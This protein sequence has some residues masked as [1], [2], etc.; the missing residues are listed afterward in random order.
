MNDATREV[1]VPTEDSQ[2][3]HYH[4]PGGCG[5]HLVEKVEATAEDLVGREL[6]PCSAAGCESADIP[7]YERC[8]GCGKPVFD[9][10]D[11][12][13]SDSA[14]VDYCAGCVLH[15]QENPNDA[16]HDQ[17]SLRPPTMLVC[18]SCMATFEDTA[19]GRAGMEDHDCLPPAEPPQEDR[20]RDCRAD[21]CTEVARPLSSYCSGEC[22]PDVD[23]TPDGDSDQGRE[24]RHCG[25]QLA[26]GDTEA[27]CPRN[28]ENTERPD[29]DAPCPNCGELALHGCW[30]PVRGYVRCGSCGLGER[31]LR[32]IAA[33]DPDDSHYTP[34]ADL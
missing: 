33:S 9:P 12:P 10:F 4:V 25:E 11:S 30:E 2:G 3:E 21:G 18:R 31:D 14:S 6:L 28:P 16:G 7:L 15:L 20:D 5:G 29:T 26:D 27:T 8:D 24:C 32:V 19:E 17:Y 1:L 34:G 23:L 22:S 13:V